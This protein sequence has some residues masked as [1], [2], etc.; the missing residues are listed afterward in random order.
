M[1]IPSIKICL[2]KR[3][4][5]NQKKKNEKGGIKKMENVKRNV[6]TI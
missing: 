2:V 1:W 5:E 6:K 3:R 4:G